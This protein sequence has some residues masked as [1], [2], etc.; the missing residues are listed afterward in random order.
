MAPVGS[1]FK[2]PFTVFDRNTPA[3]SASI[4]KTITVVSPCE[5]GLIFC[6]GAAQ[7]CASSSCA[8]R[9]NFEADGPAGLAAPQ[10][11]LAAADLLAPVLSMTSET[12]S[13]VA[14]I[15]V[16]TVCSSAL[17]ISL[18][19]CGHKSSSASA[20]RCDL[21]ALPAEGSKEQPVLTLT[22]PE[23]CPFEETPDGTCTRCSLASIEAGSCT[24]SSHTFDV[25]L[26]DTE[27]ESSSESKLHVHVHPVLAEVSVTVQ[28]N[29]VPQAAAQ[30]LD[31]PFL[32]ASQALG[33]AASSAIS[34]AA[35]GSLADASCQQVGDGRS[36][37]AILSPELNSIVQD[38]GSGSSALVFSLN[39]TIRL[40]VHTNYSSE[41]V[42]P[43]SE[44]ETGTADATLSAGA[45]DL[46]EDGYTDGENNSS[47][48]TS[49]DDEST[50]A[51]DVAMED[52]TEVDMATEDATEATASTQAA[53]VPEAAAENAAACLANAAAAS[54]TLQALADQ[55]NAAWGGAG[56]QL[57][58]VSTSLGEAQ[59]ASCPEPPP[60]VAMQQ[61][62]D[63]D[64]FELVSETQLVLEQQ[65]SIC[66]VRD[67]A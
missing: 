26:S 24:A 19:V 40:A 51:E 65:V 57:V 9:A 31:D 18:A 5:D 44:E 61:W 42:E 39:A 20:L 48:A 46:S 34:A 1:T 14:E 37:V 49:T 62:L 67:C 3:A 29:V 13:G 36:L 60:E 64:M 53:V 15:T 52:S 35:N 43:S 2:L 54:M 22:T 33:V 8:L 32:F 50:A 56:A 25:M 28:A 55:F 4:T 27:T 12:E 17:P 16:H 41:E 6:L 7:P 21:L 47:D 11:A 58:E 10:L 23:P 45:T 63:A 38:S 66:P 59:S 30:S